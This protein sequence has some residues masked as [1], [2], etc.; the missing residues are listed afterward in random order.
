MFGFRGMNL[1]MFLMF[2]I[3]QP[4]MYF[5]TRNE[6]KPKKNIMLG[7]TLSSE[8][9]HSDEVEMIGV[10]YRKTLDQWTLIVAILG[11]PA[12]FLKYV[13]ISLTWDM[14]WL[15]AVIVYPQIIYILGWK[16]LRQLKRDHGLEPTKVEAQE[17][18]VDLA[19][20]TD[21]KRE[22]SPWWYVP[23]MIMA[24]VPCVL[25]VQLWGEQMFWWMES[26][27]LTMFGCV[28]L[29]F[30]ITYRAFRRQKAEMVNDETELT[31]ALTRVRH[32]NWHKMM[33]GSAWLTG[34]FTLAMYFLMDQVLWLLI[35]TGVYTV[36]ILVLA[37][38]T[39]FTVRRV[40]EKLSRKY[41]TDDYKDEDEYWL[42]GSIYYNPKDKHVLKNART[43]M[44]MTVNL[45]TTAGKL[46]MLFGLI[47][48]L[49]MPFMGFW[50]IAEEFTPIKVC[51][52]GEALVAAHLGDE[53]VIKLDEIMSVERMDELPT[54]HKDIGTGMETLFKGQF[55]VE[56]IGVCQVLLNPQ[57]DE[58]VVVTTED[59]TYIFSVDEVLANQLSNVTE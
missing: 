10:W 3:V 58:F 33:L 36:L 25:S 31:V 43:G 34:L 9:I 40:Q 6:W 44:S 45:A 19:A 37:V 17:I 29:F 20:L 55:R 47:V 54:A 16:R 38:Q 27:Y 22:P 50:L 30:W 11:L 53:Y 14:F 21:G 56:G 12:V 32:Y 1:F 46:Y 5:T 2:Y 7:V 24:L 41:I 59:E 57:E 51:V 15:V 35:A 48:V 18:K 23:P 39:E 42:L 8:L 26:I 13:S 49:W 4:I 52:E 28:V